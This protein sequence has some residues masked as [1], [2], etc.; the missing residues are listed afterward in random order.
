MSEDLL[1]TKDEVMDV[2]VYKLRAALGGMLSL[3]V[4]LAV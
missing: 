2:A 4:L 1:T 3:G